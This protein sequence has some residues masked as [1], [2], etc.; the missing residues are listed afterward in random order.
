MKQSLT[1][2]LAT[3]CVLGCGAMAWADKL[4]IGAAGAANLLTIDAR[5]TDMDAN[6]FR[7]DSKGT[8]GTRPRDRVQ[9]IEVENETAFNAAEEAFFTGKPADSVDGFLKTMRGSQK[10]WL[11]VYCAERLLSANSKINR[12]DAAIAAYLFFVVNDPANCDKH[13]PTLPEGKNAFLDAAVNDINSALSQ[14]PSDATRMK[15]VEFMVA[16]QV[17]R[18]D[19]DGIAKAESTLAE[20][21][22]K[23]GNEALAAPLRL[24]E[25]SKLLTSKEYEKAL[26][27]IE[28]N[29]AAFV[30]PQYQAEALFLLAES[31]RGLAGKSDKKALLDAA[32]AYMRVV[33]HF[34]QGEQ[35]PHKLQCL[36]RTAELLELA[37]DLAS[38]QSVH[39]QI[40]A[41]FA[42]QPAAAAA[43]KEADRL[44]SAQTPN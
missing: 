44:K 19:Q 6:E 38:A 21:A 36:Q 10:P 34:G 5:I 23:T 33:A 40:A 28:T 24:R 27:L 3:L 17:A 25:A 11:R 13:R 30:D 9:R 8:Q 16:V 20:V 31:K 12:V 14:K 1:T 4:W 15:L 41:E 18:G 22:T 2:T 43:K 29:K 32:L 7:I 35:P 42:D 37:G 39:M 26:T